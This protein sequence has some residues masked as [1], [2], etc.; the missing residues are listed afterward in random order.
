L[1]DGGSRRAH[2][3]TDQPRLRQPKLRVDHLA[4]VREA[5]AYARPD[6]AARTNELNSD[7]RILPIVQSARAVA[8]FCLEHDRFV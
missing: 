7:I 5:R 8:A 2:R 3:K 4:F 1:D 6:C